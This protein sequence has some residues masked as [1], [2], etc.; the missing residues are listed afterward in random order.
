[1]V[2]NI[3][4]PDGN[5]SQWRHA[6]MECVKS[7]FNDSRSYLQSQINKGYDHYWVK[8]NGEKMTLEE[9]RKWAFGEFDPAN[10]DEVAKHKWYNENITRKFQTD[11]HFCHALAR[12]SHPFPPW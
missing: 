2:F 11:A 12:F 4:H 8:F 7:K 5:W 9:A 10:D 3:I 6:Y 1:M